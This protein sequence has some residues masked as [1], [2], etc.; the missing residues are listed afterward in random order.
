[1]L[2]MQRKAIVESL[3]ME[4]IEYS[5]IKLIYEPIYLNASLTIG[6]HHAKVALIEVAELNLYSIGYCLELCK[7]LREKTPECKLVLMCPE[8]GDKSKRK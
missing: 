7:N 8:Q 4:A 1:M 6:K 3:M 5:D 2:F